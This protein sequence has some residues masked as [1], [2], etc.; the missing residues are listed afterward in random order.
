MEGKRRRSAPSRS[1]N[2]PLWAKWRK[3][4]DSNPRTARTVAGFQDRCLKPL[5]HSSLPRCRRPPGDPFGPERMSSRPEPFNG[6]CRGETQG[7][8]RPRGGRD[9]R[10]PVPIGTVGE[11]TAEGRRSGPGTAGAVRIGGRRRRPDSVA[12]AAPDEDGDGDHQTGDQCADEQP[13]EFAVGGGGLVRT[14]S[15]VHTS[16]PGSAAVSPRFPI[17]DDDGEIAGFPMFRPHPAPRIPSGRATAGR[18]RQRP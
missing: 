7:G 4:W 9:G 5:G 11:R 17:G 1:L 18:R 16:P 10:P 6:G 2:L 12:D 14:V 13:H 15:I 3:R 8:R